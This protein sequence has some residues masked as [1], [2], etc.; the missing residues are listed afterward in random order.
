MIDGTPKTVEVYDA[1]NYQWVDSS[2]E[3]I[4]AVDGLEFNEE[5][6]DYY[7]HTER[8]SVSLYL[9]PLTGLVVFDIATYEKW[10]DSIR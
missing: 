8:R 7:R 6:G 9:D 2:R 1:E 4:E 3:Y 10:L 5:V